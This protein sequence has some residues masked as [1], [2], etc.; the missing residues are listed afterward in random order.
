ME[1]PVSE[2]YSLK[3]QGNRREARSLIRNMRESRSI[4]QGARLSLPDVNNAF[5]CGGIFGIALTASLRALGSDTAQ[6][7]HP[8]VIGM[9]GFMLGG[10]GAMSHTVTHNIFA[11]SRIEALLK[12]KGAHSSINSS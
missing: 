11:R 3:T 1:S 12:E 10:L 2:I 5:L 6:A 8:L 4:E 7:A 9:L